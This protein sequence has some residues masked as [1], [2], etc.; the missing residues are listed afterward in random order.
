MKAFHIYILFN[1]SDFFGVILMSSCSKKT[2][3]FQPRSILLWFLGIGCGKVIPVFPEGPLFPDHDCV[4]VAGKPRWKENRQCEMKSVTSY[5][6]SK[7][8]GAVGEN[9][10]EAKDVRNKTWKYHVSQSSTKTAL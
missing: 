4:R 2:Q 6:N 7:T 1:L 9:S 10:G 3:N 8:G 5:Y